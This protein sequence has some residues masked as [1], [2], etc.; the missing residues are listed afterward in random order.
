M[1]KQRKKTVTVRIDE[2]ADEYARVAAAYTGET[3]PELISRLL[4]QHCPPIIEEG[5]ARAEARARGEEP[6]P[7][8]S[9][10]RRR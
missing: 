9:R 5:R 8:P 1:G 4:R 6:P 7:P 2:D 3:K 10:R